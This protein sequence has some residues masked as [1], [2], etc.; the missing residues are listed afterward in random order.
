MTAGRFAYPVDIIAI[1]AAINTQ[2]KRR[3]MPPVALRLPAKET[4]DAYKALRLS[5]R[6][7][8]RFYYGRQHR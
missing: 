3:K 5:T 4:G 2:K 7:N 8:A 1:V 6:R